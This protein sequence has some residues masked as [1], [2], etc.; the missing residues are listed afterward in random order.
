MLKKYTEK[1]CTKGI[2]ENHVGKILTKIM[3][4]KYRRKLFSKSVEENHLG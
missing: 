1:S 4:K 2:E 3:Q